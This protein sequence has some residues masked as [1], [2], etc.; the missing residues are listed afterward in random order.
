MGS[1]QYRCSVASV[2]IFLYS[3][4]S[5]TMLCRFFDDRNT[6]LYN[7]GPIHQ[8]SRSTL[9]LEVNI[10]RGFDVKT[11]DLKIPHTFDCAI[12]PRTSLSH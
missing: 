11:T 6:M 2:A 8:A 9:V 3:C 10:S 1:I 12:S 5:I 7:P 4:I